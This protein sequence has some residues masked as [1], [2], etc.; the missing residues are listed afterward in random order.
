V[1]LAGVVGACD[2]QWVNGRHRSDFVMAREW[3]RPVLQY[4]GTYIV[5]VLRHGP[6]DCVGA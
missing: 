5:E 4:G 6:C 1:L 3:T 2:E